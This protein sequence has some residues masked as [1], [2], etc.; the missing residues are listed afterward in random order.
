MTPNDVMC[1]HLHDRTRGFAATVQR[2]SFSS[3]EEEIWVIR[4]K[5]IKAKG[6]NRKRPSLTQR[7]S[8]KRKKKRRNKASALMSLNN[9]IT[10]F[11]KSH[12]NVNF[13]YYWIFFPAS[14]PV[15]E[16]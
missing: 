13:V 3:K 9:S 8:E 10:R 6:N 14:S 11:A 16:L 7:K 5:K 4:G 1:Y 12:A 2:K 15:I